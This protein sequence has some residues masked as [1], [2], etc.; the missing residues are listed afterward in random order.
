MSESHIHNLN[1]KPDSIMSIAVQACACAEPYLW[2]YFHRTA[3]RLWSRL[4]GAG[5][6][7]AYALA[8]SGPFKLFRSR[9]CCFGR[10]HGAN[11]RNDDIQIRVPATQ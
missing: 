11:S 2:R 9:E 6:L 3:R 4:R 5:L 1:L 10:W 7:L 8:D